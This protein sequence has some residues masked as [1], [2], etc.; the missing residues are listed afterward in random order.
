MRLSMALKR[1]RR[2]ARRLVGVPERMDIGLAAMLGI[3]DNG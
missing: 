1:E 2:E 3:K